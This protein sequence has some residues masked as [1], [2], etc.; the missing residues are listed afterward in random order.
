MA[1]RVDGQCNHIQLLRLVRYSVEAPIV[2][3][4]WKCRECNEVLALALPAETPHALVTPKMMS[5]VFA[6]SIRRTHPDADHI[7]DHRIAA[8][9]LNEMLARASAL[10]AEPSGNDSGMLVCGKCGNGPIMPSELRCGVC[11]PKLN[12][13]CPHCQVWFRPK[14]WADDNLAHVPDHPP[15]IGPNT[16]R[17]YS[18]GVVELHTTTGAT[19]GIPED[20]LKLSPQYFEADDACS[21]ASATPCPE[22]KRSDGRHEEGCTWDAPSTPPGVEE[23]T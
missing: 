9:L 6:K 15:A 19:P 14:E 23:G 22:C 5:E 20:L 4:E 12:T 1:D 16:V 17:D 8:E 3:G 21:G 10:P 11:E 18:G 7:Y 13:R 2:F